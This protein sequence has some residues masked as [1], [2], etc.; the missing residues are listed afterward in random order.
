MQNNFVLCYYHPVCS[1]WS[2]HTHM[3]QHCLQQQSIC[4]MSILPCQDLLYIYFGKYPYC[5]LVKNDDTYVNTFFFSSL[6]DM[7]LEGEGG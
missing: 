3:S 2:A 7:K 1:D 6:L 5:F 4:A